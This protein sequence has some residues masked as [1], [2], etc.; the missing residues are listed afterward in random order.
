MS[1]TVGLL[2][3]ALYSTKEIQL[4]ACQALPFKLWDAEPQ[5]RLGQMICMQ[6]L[7]DSFWVSVFAKEQ[8]LHTLGGACATRSQVCEGGVAR[9]ASGTGTPQK[10]TENDILYMGKTPLGQRKWNPFSQGPVGQSF[11]I[12]K[13]LE[14]VVGLKP[15][16]LS[17]IFE[18]SVDQCWKHGTFWAIIKSTVPYKY[19]MD[20]E[21]FLP[22]C[23]LGVLPMFQPWKEQTLCRCCFARCLAK[24]CRKLLQLGAFCSRGPLQS[25]TALQWPEAAAK[26]PCSWT[27]ADAWPKWFLSWHRCSTLQQNLGTVH[28]W[29]DVLGLL[30]RPR[31]VVLAAAVHRG[32]GVRVVVTMLRMVSAVLSLYLAA[33]YF[34][35]YGP[36]LELPVAL[37]RLFVFNMTSS[38]ESQ[39]KEQDEDLW[40]WLHGIIYSL[41]YLVLAGLLSY[42]ICCCRNFSTWKKPTQEVY[43]RY[44]GLRGSHY[45]WKVA[46]L[47]GLT[48]LLQTL[49]KLLG[50]RISI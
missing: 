8:L 26:R 25:R 49:G 22:W 48:V 19:I 30:E 7:D 31:R 17:F 16:L 39:I 33:Q 37:E 3:D 45:T 14:I 4:P 1:V 9:A 42:D 36:P 6:V 24:V 32:N 12:L 2:G 13:Y 46:I 10:R 18:I 50:T 29:A 5:F 20:D 23:V 40:P 35:R 38:T 44:F 34:L 43:D 28:S 15:C 41:P 21:S 27:L 11:F 47:Q